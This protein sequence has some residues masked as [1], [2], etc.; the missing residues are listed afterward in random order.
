MKRNATT[1]AADQILFCMTSSF[2]GH[3][4]SKAG[5]GGAAGIQRNAGDFVIIANPGDPS[6]QI[7][8]LFL[9]C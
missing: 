5:H 2:V 4:S 3:V 8:F 6:S 1:R 7:S 9:S